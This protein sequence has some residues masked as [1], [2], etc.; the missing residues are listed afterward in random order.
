MQCQKYATRGQGSLRNLSLR[1][2]GPQ[3]W[4]AEKAEQ[5]QLDAGSGSFGSGDSKGPTVVRVPTDFSCQHGPGCTLS[6]LLGLWAPLVFALRSL[7]DF[8]PFFYGINSPT[9]N[10]PPTAP[11]TPAQHWRR[12]QGWGEGVC[13]WP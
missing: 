6:P 13:L 11:S 8:G 9:V 2:L 10:I 12:V 1:L 4:G 3:H 5:V 7:E